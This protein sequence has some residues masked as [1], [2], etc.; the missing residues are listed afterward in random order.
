MRIMRI[1]GLLYPAQMQR[2]YQQ[3]PELASHSYAEQHAA[4]SAGQDAYLQDFAPALRQHGFE[5]C[6]VFAELEPLQKRWACDHRRSYWPH[7]W[8]WQIP[9][10]QIAHYQPDI[11]YLQECFTLPFVVRKQLKNLFPFLRKVVLWKGYPHHMDELSDV[12]ALFCG[13]DNSE[14]FR[15]TGMR[16]C[17]VPPAFDPHSM[18]GIPEPV[19]PRSHPLVFAGGTSGYAEPGY[20]KRFTLLDFLLRN[21]PLHAWVCEPRWEQGERST[22]CLRLLHPDRV[23]DP[24]F[25]RDLMRLFSASAIA[26]N[27]HAEKGSAAV[28]NFR[29]FEITGA[30]ACLL[31]ESGPNL[32]VFFQEGKE[33]VRYDD[34][35]QCLER[36]RHLL[37]HPEQAQAIAQAGQQRTLR[38]HTLQR[39][40]Q[41]VANHLKELLHE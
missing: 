3:Q 28:G 32:A 1:L 20:Q 12:D 23:H 27:I 21:T 22:P 14:V 19:W 36:I 6:E 41:V 5:V 26:L 4:L 34:A 10:Q 38:T 11:L 7:D 9:L 24:L 15:Q 18:A 13:P 33:M 35:C 30:G 29:M 8:S 17:E 40:W 25:G 2:I 37:N 31:S 39:R 16:C